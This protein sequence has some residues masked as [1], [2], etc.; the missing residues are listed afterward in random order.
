VDANGVVRIG[1]LVGEAAVVTRFMGFVHAARI[2]VPAE[3]RL[4]EDSFGSLP[5]NNFVD[6]LADAQF[7]KLGLFPSELCTDAEF[8]RRASLDTIGM[9]PTPNEARSFPLESAP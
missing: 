2:T 7:S 9:L 3:Q 6:E 4:P 1:Q 5:R 8:L